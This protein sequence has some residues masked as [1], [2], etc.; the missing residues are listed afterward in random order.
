[1][2]EWRF[3]LSFCIP[4]PASH[5]LHHTG[6]WATRASGRQPKLFSCQCFWMGKCQ[7]Y[8]CL[9]ADLAVTSLIN[10]LPLIFV[11]GS[12][13]QVQFIAICIFGTEEQKKTQGNGGTR[14][15]EQ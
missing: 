4:S 2:P 14:K 9:G 11:S 5:Q 13:F 7:E 10:V 3:E 6:S 8:R 12:S 15:E 1:M